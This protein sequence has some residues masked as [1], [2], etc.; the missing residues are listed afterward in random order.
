MAELGELGDRVLG[1][2]L[3]AVGRKISRVFVIGGR[4]AHRAQRVH[5]WGKPARCYVDRPV[6]LR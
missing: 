6:R 2:K 1:E 4:G 3:V 5:V